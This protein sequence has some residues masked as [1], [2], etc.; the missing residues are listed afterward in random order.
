M[1]IRNFLFLIF[2]LGTLLLVGCSADIESTYNDYKLY[3][4]VAKTKCDDR[5]GELIH[6]GL[7]VNPISEEQHYE[8]V[9]FKKDEQHFYYE[10]IN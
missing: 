5:S 9:C 6:F 1:K 10:L 4:E 8:S 7:I 3:Q 2:I